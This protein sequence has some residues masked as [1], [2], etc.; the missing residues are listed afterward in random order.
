MNCRCDATSAQDPL[1]LLPRETQPLHDPPAQDDAQLD[2]AVESDPVPDAERGGLAMSWSRI[3]MARASGRVICGGEH[4]P[5]VG[6]HVAFGVIGFWLGDAHHG[7]RFRQDGG[8]RSGTFQQVERGAGAPAGEALRSSSR[9][10][11]GATR[12][13]GGRQPPQGL[14]R[15]RVDGEL[16]AGGE[17]DGPHEHGGDLR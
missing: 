7:A 9:M 10:R 4:R 6:E 8:E 5:H 14:P 3:P 11:S 12:R 17:P 15:G 2:V 13:D 1:G 16:Q